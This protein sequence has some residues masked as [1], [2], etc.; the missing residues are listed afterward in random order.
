MSAASK[1]CAMRPAPPSLAPPADMWDRIRRGF[2][3][4][5]LDS[6]LVRTQEQW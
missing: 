1:S 6:D 5:N 2:N 4:P 3:M